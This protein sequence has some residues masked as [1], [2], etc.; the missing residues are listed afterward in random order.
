MLK[1][2]LPR[3]STPLGRIFE[4]LA[5]LV[6]GKGVGALLSLVYIA[7]ITRSLGPEDFGRF[8]LIFSAATA[9]ALLVGFDFWQVV[10]KF[11]Q[12]HVRDQDGRG[13]GRLI[14][15]G[16][17]ADL[18][19]G[20]IGIAIAAVAVLVFGPGLGL[21]PALEAEALGFAAVLLLS[22]RSTPMGVLRLFN[23]FDAATF[24]ETAVPVMRMVGALVALAVGPT[25][26]AFLMAWAAAEIV[27]AATYWTLALRA[28]RREMGPLDTSGF[29]HALSEPGIKAFMGVTHANSSLVAASAQAPVLMVGAFIGPA[30]AGLYRLS[31]QIAQ[32]MTKVSSLFSRSLYSE[33][34]HVSAVH[35]RDE[36]HALVRK[37]TLMTVS[38][39]VV[40]ALAILV[41]GKPVLLA[42]SGP[43]YA[44]AFPLLVILGIAA[45]I[46]MAGSGFEP[47]L[48]ATDAAVRAMTFRI[49]S[50]VVLVTGLAL[51]LPTFGAVGGAWAVLLTAMVNFAMVGTAAW[52]AVRAD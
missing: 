15:L 23:R 35:S 52:R 32:S 22:L 37:T 2:S 7:I 8:S 44:D 46:D 41:A 10:V 33:L 36:L 11:G 5:W 38:A 45:A 14:A 50:L 39:A 16:A 13:L 48:M 19:A 3:G 17:A 30:Q 40:S 28:A 20:L 42:I 29:P 21:S 18:T 34:A 4:H 49:I 6:S 51:L 43:E 27:C 47:L 12:R 26:G 31:W 24:S 25:I 9:L 1:V